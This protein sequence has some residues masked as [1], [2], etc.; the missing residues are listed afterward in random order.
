MTNSFEDK[1]LRFTG[2]GFGCFRRDITAAVSCL[3]SFFHIAMCFFF[4]PHDQNDTYHREK[5]HLRG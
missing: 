2:F 1:N 5:R 3:P 4:A